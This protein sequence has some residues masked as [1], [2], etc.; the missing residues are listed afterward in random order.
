MGMGARTRIVCALIS[1]L[2]LVGQMLLPI[3]RAQ[4]MAASSGDPL[5]Y[6]WCGALSPAAMEALRDSLPKELFDKA[7]G[8][9]KSAQPPCGLCSAHGQ[10]MAAGPA[11][12][13]A[14]SSL[15]SAER[16][17]APLPAPPAVTQL[18]LPPSHAPP[19]IA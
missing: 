13:F 18:L 14:L 1:V 17:Q 6:V 19:R 10:A 7:G 8:Q 3:A 16:L 2:A 4:S 15:A 9:A 12:S 11:L 5:A